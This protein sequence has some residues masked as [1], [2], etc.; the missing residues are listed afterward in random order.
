VPANSEEKREYLRRYYQLHREKLISAR[1]R[2]YELRRKE[3]AEGLRLRKL[4]DA[5]FA[6]KFRD[7]NREYAQVHKKEIN[8]RRRLWRDKHPEE[9]RAVNEKRRDYVQSYNR[10]HRED[11]LSYYRLNKERFSERRRQ[12]ML[13]WRRRNPEKAALVSRIAHMLRRAK[14]KTNGPYENVDPVVVFLRDEGRC[15]ICGALVDPKRFDV[16]HIIPIS[17]GGTHQ[18][19]NVQLAHPLCN[20]KKHAKMPSAIS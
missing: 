17:R 15:G 4:S 14:I 3:I 7:R 11:H 8:E 16:D 6:K 2:Y 13:L 9:V 12:Y 20:R 1:H 19:S 5:D 18:M 10:L